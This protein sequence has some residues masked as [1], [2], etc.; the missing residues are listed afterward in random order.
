M[1]I[2]R[3][4]GYDFGLGLF[5]TM[6]IDDKGNPEFLEEH[7]LRLASGCRYFDVATTV[8]KEQVYEYIATHQLKSCVLKLSV[9]SDN[10]LFSTREISY[11]PA[12]YQTGFRLTVSPIRKNP[13]SPFTYYKTSNYGDCLWAKRMAQRSG[14]DEALLLNDKGEICEGSMSNIFF[15]KG[16]TFYTPPVKSGLLA[17]VYRGYLIEQLDVIEKPLFLTDLPQFDSCFITNSVMKKMPVRCI[18]D[19]FFKD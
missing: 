6:L 11:Q 12:D 19:Y 17:G 8:S 4:A 16:E 10:L 14:F 5:E 1:L 18:D 15:R 2:T 7:L 9:S 3:D 13:T